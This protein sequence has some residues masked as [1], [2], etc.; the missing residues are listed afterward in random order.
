MIPVRIL[1]AA[2]S[3]VAAV[4]ALAALAGGA[5]AQTGGLP[6]RQGTGPITIEADGGIEWHQSS[7]TYIARGNAR[8][9]Q[10]DVTVRAEEMTAHYRDSAKGG[11]E[12]WR[13]DASG[14]VE[15]TAPDRRAT[16]SRGV[17]DVD[18]RLLILTG[19]PR[20]ETARDRIT[21]EDSLEF[22][23][24]RDLA[25]ARGNAAAA[26]DG[27]RLRAGV[28]SATFE[29][30]ASG[31]S[32]VRRIDAFGDV[33]ISTAEEIVRADRGAYDLKTGIA[34][35]EGSVK[36]TRGTDQLSGERAEI[37]LNT[38]MSRLFGGP[39]GARGIFVPK[40][41]RRPQRP[42]EPRPGTAR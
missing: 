12:V 31:E 2:A 17:Y 10:G 23:Q 8:A 15:I 21:A 42:A 18:R 41:A 25:V 35:L 32:R 14:G 24:D 13:I 26:R 5:S 19:A 40:P 6:F 29:T 36:I 27:R 37:D 33:L 39:G 1:V 7:R 38:G 11:T 34:K 20:L 30:D 9:R 3:A 28:L 4:A 16:A 22:W